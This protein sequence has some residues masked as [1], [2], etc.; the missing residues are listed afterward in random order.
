[1]NKIVRRRERLIK[2]Y[3]FMWSQSEEFQKKWNPWDLQRECVS[4]A[5]FLIGDISQKRLLE[6]G[7][8]R[9]FEAVN[10]VRRNAKVFCIDIS[11]KSLEITRQLDSRPILLKMDVQRMGFK[12]NVFDIIYANNLLMNIDLHQ[13]MKEISRVLKPTGVA[14]FV[15]PLK[16][17]PIALAF[18]KTFH[19][20]K[21]MNPKYISYEDLDIIETFFQEN[22]HKEFDFLSGSVFPFYKFGPKWKIFS[23]LLAYLRKLDSTFLK[24]FPGLNKYCWQIVISAKN[25]SK[26]K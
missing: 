19:I 18:R 26:N 3:D 16:N 11:V 9:G 6:I 8:G 21:N 15:E 1:M 12:T 25:P 20:A 2:F 17:H 14:V 5:Y 13:T 22:K 4:Y 10:F 23:Y 24:I 7:P